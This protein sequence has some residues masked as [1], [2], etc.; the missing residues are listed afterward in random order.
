[1]TMQR[2]DVLKIMTAASF[3]GLYGG[4][5]SAQ[6]GRRRPRVRTESVWRVFE[7]PHL[8]E[9]AFP[10]GGIGTGCVSVGGRGEL[11]DWE[12]FNRPNKRSTLENTCFSLWFQQD[13]EES[14]AMILESRLSPPFRGGFGL[15][16]DSMPGMPRFASAQFLGSYPFARVEF[17]DD[18]VPLD[19]SLECFNPMIPGNPEDSGIPAAIFY[20]QIENKAKKPVTLTVMGSLQNVIG[21]DKRGGGVNEYVDEGAF[22]GIRMTNVKLDHRDEN[23]GSMALV[24]TAES[25]TYAARWDRGGWFDAQSLFWND[26][27]EDGLLEPLPK[28]DPSPD[29]QHDTASLGARL[30]LAPG[31][32]ASVP[33]FITW[34]F[35]NRVNYWNSEKE[36]KE[37]DGSDPFVG[38]HYATRF[39]SAWNAAEYTVKNLERLEDETRLFHEALFSSSLP[40]EALDAISSQMSIIRTQTC[41]RDHN[42]NF[43]AFE[44]T[45]DTGGCC[46]LNCTHVWNYE[47]ALAHLFPSLERTMRVVDFNVNTSGVGRMAFRTLLPLGKA[48]WWFGPA[49]DGQMGTVVK[50]YREWKLSGDMDFL[51]KVWPNAK[52]ALEF[53]WTEWDP[54]KSGV[55][56]ER[57]HNTYDIE[58]YGPNPMMG[59][60]YLC[61]LRAGEEMARALGDDASADEYR[62]VYDKGSKTLDEKTWNGEYYIQVYDPDQH[63]KYQLGDGCLS[64]Q[65][66]G[67]W[68]SHVAGLGYHLPEDR[69]KSAIHAVYQY[70]FKETLS[71][72]YNPQRIYALGDEGGLLLC[73]WP[74][75]NRPA[76]PFVYSDEV[77]T[78]IEYQVAAHLIYEGFVEEG[79][80]VVKAVRN[81][82]DGERR[83]PWNEVECGHHYARAMAS[84]SVLLALSGF[85]FDAPARAIG[86]QPRVKKPNFT[87]FWSA[88]PGWGV[89]EQALNGRR[90]QGE[91]KV[92]YGQ[93]ELVRFTLPAPGDAIRRQR[94]EAKVFAGENELPVR[95]AALEGER[96]VVELETPLLIPRGES[97]T[98][99]LTA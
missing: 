80:N 18:E 10:L 46:P 94:I 12:I 42:G 43:F 32:R 83:N 64:D 11:R 52:K 4:E 13:G 45:H 6:P 98:V 70:N 76:L 50:L 41:F 85:E 84:W 97:V 38:N 71:H 81:R 53:A 68:M 31:E 17:V 92:H 55:M 57:Q 74:R 7:E 30:R 67:Q 73:S 33:F 59:A 62:A 29:G 48:F 51:K 28:S 87:C 8:S 89:Y 19:V 82:Y 21:K 24:T 96:G 90:L 14:R 3:A 9:I 26:F 16:R 93:A 61:A 49:A 20:W 44:G 47:Q 36:L 56:T 37:K 78:G 75:G 60:I 23:W 88:G 65:L 69:V 86:F 1:M 5:A 77:W 40:P 99:V 63:T 72:H 54:E 91:I 95:A 22:R 34:R 79:M 2:R 35:P 15:S 25:V 27:S 58:F 39:T 66:L